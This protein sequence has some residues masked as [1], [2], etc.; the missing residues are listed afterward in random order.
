MKIGR[1][2]LASVIHHLPGLS[3]PGNPREGEAAACSLQAAAGR[4]LGM[5]VSCSIGPRGR[6]GDPSLYYPGSEEVP[7]TAAGRRSREL[8]PG[9]GVPRAVLLLCVAT[10][11]W[12]RSWAA[13]TVGECSD[14]RFS[15]VSSM[16]GRIRNV[17]SSE[18][19][20]EMHLRG[21]GAPSS[22]SVLSRIA[23]FIG[24]SPRSQ[25]DE[26]LSGRRR[27]SSASPTRTPTKVPERRELA[28]AAPI[29]LHH[30]CS[31]AV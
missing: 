3:D 22:P 19:A 5:A 1:A 9:R 20:A 2:R 25:R 27:P 18:L 21:G 14:R 23:S 31:A 6:D 7:R 12:E 26:D 10:L 24:F 15:S 30:S 16:H 4:F 28:R 8:H 13:F 29:P 11:G 17:W